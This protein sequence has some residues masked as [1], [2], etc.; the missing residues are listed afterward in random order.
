[1]K[2]SVIICTHNP[3]TDY[4]ART[5]EALQTQTLPRTEWELLLVDNASAEALSASYDLSWHPRGRHLHEPVM[6]LT[7]ARLLGIRQAAGELLVL[8]DDDNLLTDDYLNAA[9][10]IA[11]RWPKIG[12]FGGQICAEFESKPPDWTL[13]YHEMLAIRMFPR[14]LWANFPTLTCAPCGAGMC[15][16]SAVAR[17]YAELLANDPRRSALDRIGLGL[18]SY[19]DIDLAWCACDLGLGLG[20]FTALVLTHLIPSRR[21]EKSYLLELAEA[22]HYSSHM[23]DFCRDGRVPDWSLRT[24]L[25]E[26]LRTWRMPRP[27]SE[28]RRAAA[29]GRARAAAVLGVAATPPR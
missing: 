8:V 2:L 13:P 1:M 10:E 18:S 22:V 16:R 23:L 14:D 19:G 9:V 5:L 27:A 21:L 25:V 12:A 6:G 15:L 7:T 28:F 3:R 11:Y 24:R 4:L 17:Y 29:R 20:Q 26:A